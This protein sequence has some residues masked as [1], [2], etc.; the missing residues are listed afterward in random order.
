MSRARRLARVGL[1]VPALAAVALTSARS[2]A[3]DRF[4]RG[5]AASAD[6]TIRVYNLSG[7]TAITGWD[8]DS[9]AIVA[10]LAPGAGR[11]YLGGHDAIKLG[12]EPATPGGTPG[13]AR[14]EIRVPRGSVLWVKAADASIEVEGVEGGLDLYSV[15]GGV[16]VRGAPATVRAESME[17]PISIEARTPWLRAKTASGSIDLAGEVSDL[18]ATSVSGA[19]RVAAARQARARIESV[20]GEIVVSGRPSRG[21]AWEIETHSGPVTLVLA[22]DTDA[23]IDV[24]TFGG[25]VQADLGRVVSRRIDDLAGSDWKILVGS[26]GTS[27]T[28][29]TFKAPVSVRSAR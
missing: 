15:S 10:E 3:Q 12:V 11:L 23:E 19:I 24:H 29:R 26:G 7:S 16:R 18:A 1:V 2:P 6:A 28:V 25:D 27:M 21:G 13:S 4:E 20:T 22:P 14:L 5:L 9:V 8:R 17:G